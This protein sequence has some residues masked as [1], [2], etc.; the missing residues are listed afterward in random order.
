MGLGSLVKY[1]RLKGI[2]DEATLIDS[3]DIIATSGDCP[4]LGCAGEGTITSQT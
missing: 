4:C 2:E 1:L 3:L